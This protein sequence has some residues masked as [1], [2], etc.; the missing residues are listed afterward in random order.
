MFAADSSRKPSTVDDGDLQEDFD[1]APDEHSSSSSSSSEDL[2]QF[3]GELDS[4]TMAGDEVTA[5]SGARD[6]LELKHSAGSMIFNSDLSTKVR[7]MLIRHIVIITSLSCLFSHTVF[8]RLYSLYAFILTMS[9]PW[10]PLLCIS[11]LCVKSLVYS[12]YD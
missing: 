11:E 9:L 3:I 7:L 4:G 5:L 6:A 8:L 10:L 12:V 2:S 1:Q